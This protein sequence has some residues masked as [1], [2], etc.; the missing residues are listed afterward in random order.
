MAGVALVAV[1]DAI[2]G[3]NGSFGHRRGTPLDPLLPFMSWSPYVR[4]S[5]TGACKWCGTCKSWRRMGGTQPPKTGCHSLAPGQPT[6]NLSWH[7]SLVSADHLLV[8]AH[9]VLTSTCCPTL[10]LPVEP[11]DFW[12][13]H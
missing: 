1:V 7:P 8:V 6:F 11:I 5:L 13:A 9:T 10:L 3:L 2:I 12:F 4:S